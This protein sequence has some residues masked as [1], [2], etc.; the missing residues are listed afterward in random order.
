MKFGY[1]VLL[2]WLTILAPLWGQINYNYPVPRSDINTSFYPRAFSS[3]PYAQ[4]AA[5]QVKNVIFCIGD[6]MGFGQIALTRMSAVGLEGR[7][8]MERLPVMGAVWTYSAN[9]VVTDSAAAGTALTCG[10]KT[11]NQWLGLTPDGT[12]WSTIQE[13]AQA[14]GMKTGIVVTSTVTHATPAAFYA[15]IRSRNDEATIAEQLLA[16]HVN[17]VLG[18]GQQFFMPNDQPGS[19]RKDKQDLLALAREEDYHVITDAA[20][21]WSAQDPYLLGLFQIGPLTTVHP[22]PSLDE[23][24]AK[25][26][27]LLD[28]QTKGQ[29]QGFFLMIEGSQIDWAC[30]SN[31]TQ[32]MIR[33]TLLF[34]Q[35][36]KTVVDYTL[37]HP[38]TLVIVTADHETG[39][40]TLGQGQHP[41]EPKVQWA[42][43]DHTALPVP[44]FAIGPGSVQFENL[45]DNTD[46]PRKIAGLLDIHPFPVKRPVPDS[47]K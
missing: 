47:V 46:I 6:G 17:V 15:H 2:L 16:A 41:F 9:A 36:V 42:S 12:A 30:H 11:R 32:S 37:Q 10:V 3:E 35:T 25:A 22:E 24:A 23:M 34:D 28:A 19:K 40:L 31:D 5:N 7:L 14:R 45:Q 4:P 20:Q 18:G 38:Q 43:K 44:I 8:Y 33:Q 13:L 21:L 1:R 26:L 27:S 39:G 29:K